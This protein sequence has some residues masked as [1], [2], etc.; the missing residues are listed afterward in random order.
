MKGKSTTYAFAQR[1]GRIG[2]NVAAVI[3][4]AQGAFDN[5]WWPSVYQLHLPATLVG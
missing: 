3:V 2:N 4:D 5:I 1:Y